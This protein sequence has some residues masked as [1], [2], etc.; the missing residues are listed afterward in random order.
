MHEICSDR[1]TVSTRKVREI[2]SV[3]GFVDSSGDAVVLGRTVTVTFV[4]MK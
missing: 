1:G 2:I 3:D 4:Q